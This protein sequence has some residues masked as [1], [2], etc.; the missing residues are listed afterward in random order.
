MIEFGGTLSRYDI[1]EI[2]YTFKHSRSDN[3][4]E[5]MLR[6]L[7]ERTLE[8]YE[9]AMFISATSPYMQRIN[10]GDNI[11]DIASTGGSGQVKFNVSTAVAFVVASGG[12]KVAKHCGAGSR[13][14]SGSL[15]FLSALGCQ[16]FP[17]RM[18]LEICIEKFGLCFIPASFAHRRLWKNVRA[19]RARIAEPTIFNLL[20]PLVNPVR[21]AFHVIGANT[22][23]RAQ[24]LAETLLLL[25]PLRGAVVGNE[26]GFD[27]ISL[28]CE[29]I[30][31][32][33]DSVKLILRRSFVS[34]EDFGIESVSLG[35]ILAGDSAYNA[36]F[37]VALLNEY[38]DGPL[39]RLLAANAALVFAICGRC[40]TLQEGYVLAQDLL[41]RGVVK[42]KFLQYKNFVRTANG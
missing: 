19:S 37:F 4:I 20:G 14:P 27:E 39:P 12:I 1:E 10:L 8:P 6:V 23:E 41:A 2:L 24:L 34:H 22:I 40:T 33:V 29:N 31:W 32:E 3:E 16:F 7:N 11:C 42:E 36:E 25:F 26:L 38:R 30:L 18:Q 28:G 15:D 9:L 17:S 13:G 35:T 21:T 5:A